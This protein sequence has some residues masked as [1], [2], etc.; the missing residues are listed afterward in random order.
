MRLLS[1]AFGLSC[2]VCAEDWPQF[3][4]PTGQGHSKESGLPLEW[5]ETSNIRWKTAIPGRGWS[6]P[7][8]QGNRI[9]VTSATD[10]GRSLRLLGFDLATGALVQNT[11]V[12]A[13]TGEIPIHD[14][15]S[16]ASPTPVLEGDRIY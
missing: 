12:F 4:G 14:K 9:W 5:S 13:L 15:N 2:L 16:Q 7:A 11:E 6:S 8:I 3:R 1:L 10:N